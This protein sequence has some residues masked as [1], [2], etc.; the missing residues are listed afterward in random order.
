MREWRMKLPIGEF[1][2]IKLGLKKIEGRAALDSDV[3]KKFSEMEKGNLLIFE[4]VDENKKILDEETL[5]FEVLFNNCYKGNSED[6]IREMFEKEGLKKLLP[7]CDS[8]EEGVKI[9]MGF[10]GYPKRI[11]EFGIYAIGLGKQIK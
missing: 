2:L 8:I 6:A 3:N 1:K 7:N 4:A 5:A 9:Y 11:S 10:P